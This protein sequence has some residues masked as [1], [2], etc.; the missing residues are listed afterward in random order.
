MGD[1][2]VIRNIGKGESLRRKLR[3]C[4]AS[5]AWV[6]V[7]SLGPCRRQV[8]ALCRLRWSLRLPYRAASL[9]E[10]SSLDAWRRL[11]WW[12]TGAFANN[13]RMEGGQYLAGRRAPPLLHR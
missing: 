10:I 13:G 5:H 12:S 3:F 4:D 11:R 7:D 1:R 2:S 9:L 8:G 6:H